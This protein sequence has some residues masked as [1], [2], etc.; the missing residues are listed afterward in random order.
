MKKIQVRKTEPVRL[1]GMAQP[2]YGVCRVS[3]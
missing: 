1:T 3:T 2:L